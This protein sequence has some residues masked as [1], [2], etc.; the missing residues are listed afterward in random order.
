MKINKKI[1]Y[2][3]IFVF[4]FLINVNSVKAEITCTY[5]MLP[6]N[7]YDN[8]IADTTY[9]SSKSIVTVSVNSKSDYT[10]TRVQGMDGSTNKTFKDNK[11]A[12]EVANSKKCPSYVNANLMGM[13]YTI[14]EIDSTKFLNKQDKFMTT[15]KTA[16]GIEHPM[17]LVK[18][19]GKTVDTHAVLSASHAIDKWDSIITSTTFTEEKQAAAK[20]YYDQIKKNDTLWNAMTTRGTWWTKFSNFALGDNSEEKLLNEDSTEYVRASRNDCYYYCTDFKCGTLPSGTGKDAC[21]SSC[22]S[23]MMATCISAYNTANEKC[24]NIKDSTSKE[25]CM[26]AQ[27]VANGV[28]SEYVD[29][30]TSR[31]TELQN[32]IIRLKKTIDIKNKNKIKIEVGKDPYKVT[33]DDVKI[34]HQIWVIILILAP[35]LVVVFGTLDFGKAVI[36]SNEENIKKA[37]KKFPK[38]LLA[39]VL[40]ILVP[41]LISLIL[42]I[43]TDTSA[44][45]TSLMYCIINGG[46]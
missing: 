32:E 9:L 13:N 14:K 1:I 23:S 5:E 26:K 29:L 2:I 24:E 3:F 33:C 10:I 25:Q 30:R 45:D 34:F 20:A 7:Y 15:G 28:E 44:G 46:E 4:M 39:V 19:N 35:V 42:S 17:Y 36:S 37:W 27:L 11:F 6:V 40:L 41:T 38:R 8:V 43:T 22:N 12:K 16:T 31:M 21:V 18:E